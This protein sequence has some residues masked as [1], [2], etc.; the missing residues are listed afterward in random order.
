[1]PLA[2]DVVGIEEEFINLLQHIPGTKEEKQAYFSSR[3]IKVPRTNYVSMWESLAGRLHRSGAASAVF[4]LLR[5]G[6]PGRVFDLLR[7]AK[8]GRPVALYA[9][10]PAIV[11]DPSFETGGYESSANYFWKTW[12]AAA[13]QWGERHPTN[14]PRFRRPCPR[15]RIRLLT[16]HRR[17]ASRNTISFSHMHGRTKR[18]LPVL[19]MTHLPRRVS[20]SGSTRRS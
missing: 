6:M 9:S 10:D 16:I 1:M 17:G 19:F 14:P 11:E 15:H 4:E 13:F 12:K 8:Q 7:T 3:S 2:K 18:Q 20:V 5:T